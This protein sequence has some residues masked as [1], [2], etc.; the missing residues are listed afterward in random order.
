MVIVR[1]SVYALYL[2]RSALW[3]SCHDN[4]I[5]VMRYHAQIKSIYPIRNLRY[6]SFPLPY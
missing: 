3:M 4:T 5:I 2:R 1:D 6:L